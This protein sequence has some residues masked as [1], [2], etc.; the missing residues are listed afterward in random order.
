MLRKVFPFAAVLCIAIAFQAQQPATNSA[1]RLK[2]LPVSFE[3]NQGQVDSP[4]QFLAHAGQGTMYFTPGEA[5]LALASRDSQKK[6]QV[7]VLR[8]QWIGANLHPQILAEQPLPGKINY[9]IGRNPAQ[10]HTGIPT[11]A[12]V[13]YRNLFPGVDAVFYGKEGEIEYDLLLAPGAD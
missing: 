7:S 11:F 10:W 5:V 9:L 1:A 12:R 8:L 4:V 13:R 2:A 6:S 3:Q